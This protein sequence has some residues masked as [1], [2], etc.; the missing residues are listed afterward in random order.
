MVKT[1]RALNPGLKII[2]SKNH[3]QM[4]PTVKFCEGGEF[5]T[6]SLS[7]LVSPGICF[8]CDRHH[9]LKM[10][11]MGHSSQ[12]V[13]SSAVVCLFKTIQ[14]SYKEQITSQEL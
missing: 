3:W 11:F 4:W 7:L 12:K 5:K 9:N 6:F 2:D 8:C 10:I 14:N 1:G 13:K